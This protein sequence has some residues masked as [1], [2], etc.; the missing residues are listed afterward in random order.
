MVNSHRRLTATACAVLGI[1]FAYSIAWTCDDAW[2]SFRY[3]RNFV[4]GLGLVFNPGERVE[5]Y[6][7]FSWTLLAALGIHLG[8]GVESWAIGLGLLSYG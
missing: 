2:I 7:N 1:L 3:A 6:T 8:A 5:G 4:E